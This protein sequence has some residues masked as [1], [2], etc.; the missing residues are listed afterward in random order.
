[1]AWSLLFGWMVP[2]SIG[3]AETAPRVKVALGMSER[4]VTYYISLKKRNMFS[5]T[6][7][8]HNLR[9]RSYLFD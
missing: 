2:F 3:I 6:H 8:G 9:V 4:W 7:T 5:A 1:M